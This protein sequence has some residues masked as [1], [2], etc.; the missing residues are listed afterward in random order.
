MSLSHA[1]AL[2][3]SCWD[4]CVEAE[5]AKA[6]FA[7]AKVAKAESV[8]DLGQGYA[9]MNL[10]LLLLLGPEEQGPSGPSGP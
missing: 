4:N 10:F 6:K 3:G 8:R 5:L 9:G 2:L 7:K 1:N